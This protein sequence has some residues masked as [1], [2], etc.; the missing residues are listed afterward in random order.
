MLTSLATGI[1]AQVLLN[2]LTASAGDKRDAK[3]L[4][5]SADERGG[6]LN[7]NVPGM[8]EVG[9]TEIFHPQDASMAATELTLGGQ[10][11]TAA[12]PWADM[13]Q[14]VLDQ[15][16]FFHHATYTPVHGEHSRV[17]KLMG[18]TEK[19]DMLVSLLAA[20]LAPMLGSVRADPISLGARGPELLS[21]AGRL[22]GNVAPTSVAQALGGV[23]GPLANLRDLRDASIDRVYNLYKE[24]GTPN[25]LRLL[26]AW[27]RSRDDVRNV[28]TSLL[29]RLDGITNDG[30]EMQVRT[31][32]VLAAMNISPV[33]TIHLNFGGDTHVDAGLAAE[34]T[35]YPLAVGNI[36]LLAQEL[37]ALEAE[38]SLPNDV[39]FA[40][41]N[42]FG[43]TLKKQGYGG[44]DHNEGHHTMVLIGNGVAPGVIGGVAPTPDNDDY[45]A[46]PIDSSTGAAAVDGDIPFEETLGAAGK[47]LGRVLGVDVARLDEI[48]P[49][50]KIVEA[51][52]S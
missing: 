9:P 48:A 19:N 35:K 46:Q 25:Q 3:V 45:I 17:M 23:E 47:T 40:S 28:S 30:E 18:A 11:W 50:G 43:R 22:L 51:A 44:R 42:V 26:D 21:S 32:A 2:P 34:T 7:A 37:A 4:I 27:V 10:T 13:P 49:P 36:Q 15:T 14:T 31:A 5:L 24:R 39:I 16:C 8:Y 33:I 52:L 1:P 6:P 20:E 38:G 29:S 12:K 41:L